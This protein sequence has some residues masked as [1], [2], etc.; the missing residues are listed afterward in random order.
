LTWDYSTSISEKGWSLNC[1]CGSWRCRGVIVP[2]GELAPHERER[3]RSIA[4]RYLQ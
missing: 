4:L 3:L 1:L 2:F